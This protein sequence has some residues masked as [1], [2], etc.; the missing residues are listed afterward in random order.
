MKM[1]GH[2]REACVSGPEQPNT[3]WVA[4]GCVTQTKGSEAAAGAE[5]PAWLRSNPNG[6]FRGPARSRTG[7]QAAVTRGWGGSVKEDESD[8]FPSC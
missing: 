6:D 8:V 4:A 1:T 2:K 5:E 7:C 3:T